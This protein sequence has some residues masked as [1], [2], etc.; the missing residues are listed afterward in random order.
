MLKIIKFIKK[1]FNVLIKQSEEIKLIE[2]L[3]LIKSLVLFFY[4]KEKFFLFKMRS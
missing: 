1:N 2:K 3:H 4:I